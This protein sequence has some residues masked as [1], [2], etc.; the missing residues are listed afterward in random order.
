MRYE[1]I[2]FR[3]TYTQHFLKSNGGILIKIGSLSFF[4]I[5]CSVCYNLDDNVLFLLFDFK[6]INFFEYNILHEYLNYV[7]RAI[8]F[9]VI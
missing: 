3:S 7:E 6:P 9:K 8:F 2:M 1:N 5:I 4:N